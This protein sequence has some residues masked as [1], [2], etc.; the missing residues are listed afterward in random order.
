M[1]NLNIKR[2]T[3]FF[4]LLSIVIL[5][6]GKTTYAKET[7]TSQE[8]T[9]E[10]YGKK[11]INIMDKNGLYKNTKEWKEAKKEV[12]E[13]LKKVKT[14]EETYPIIE[15]AIKVAGGKHSFFIKKPLVDETQ[16]L[17][18]IEYP[19]TEYK[20]NI[21]TLKLPSYVGTKEQ[22]QKYADTLANKIITSKNLKGVVVDL[23]ENGGGDMGPMLAGLAPLLPDGNLMYFES[24]RG[25]SPV[26]LTKGLISGGGMPTRAKVGHIKV[27]TKVAIL[28]GENTAS[29]AEATFISF[30]GLDNVKS[31]GKPTAGYASAN[32]VIPLADGAEMVLTIAR[33]K[34]R[35]GEV[36][37]E[38]PIVPDMVTDN[39]LEEAIK[40][41]NE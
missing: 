15:K 2:C 5:G 20:D 25:T 26:K 27:K 28:T 38:D 14:Y 10:S 34:A 23:R 1:K 29:S 33:D 3:V 24:N 22:G 4:M 7:T 36:F 21:L 12:F 8:I 35:T 30:M 6:V 40:W 11:A 37:A 41:I 13:D 32:T 19:T 39:P 31:F 9:A 18:A 17:N 16:E